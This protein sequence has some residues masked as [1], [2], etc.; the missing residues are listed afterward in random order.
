MALFRFNFPQFQ[1]NYTRRD[2]SFGSQQLLLPYQLYANSCL[3]SPRNLLTDQLNCGKS[4][5]LSWT[6]AG[7]LLS[8]AAWKHCPMT[9]ISE[10]K[11][12]KKHH[13]SIFQSRCLIMSEHSK[14]ALQARQLFCG[15]FETFHL[16]SELRDC[17]FD[18]VDAIFH[19]ASCVRVKRAHM[20]IHSI[21]RGSKINWG[22][23]PLFS[24]PTSIM[25]P[26]IA[27]CIKSKWLTLKL[28]Q[29]RWYLPKVGRKKNGRYPISDGLLMWAE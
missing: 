21:K 8:E 17:C 24:N 2:L 27:N 4:L 12:S 5:I 20:N 10:P 11:K 9:N 23:V 26:D 29:L 16:R 14:W 1:T 28:D 18:R 3:V 6:N 13:E 7:Q 15:L 19:W 22:K 25:I